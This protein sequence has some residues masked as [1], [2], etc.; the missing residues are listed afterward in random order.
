VPVPFAS[1]W[2][3]E[4]AVRFHLFLD[5]ET[6]IVQHHSG[7]TLEALGAGD[8]WSEG[9]SVLTGMN[10]AHAEA[11]RILAARMQT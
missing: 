7:T 3:S 1:S 9:E 10:K 11:K 4:E 8:W 2:T 6:R 5:E